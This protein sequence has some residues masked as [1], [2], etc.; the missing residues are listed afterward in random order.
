MQVDRLGYGLREKNNTKGEKQHMKTETRCSQKI[1]LWGASVALVLMQFTLTSPAQSAARVVA[2][3]GVVGGRTI[4]QWSGDWWRLAISALDFPFPRNVAQPGALGNVK[5]P[6]FFAVASPGPGATVYT[7]KV[8]RGKH[9][10]LPLYT[11]VWASQTFSDPCSDLPCSRALANRFVHGTKAL[12]VRIDG[13]PVRNLFSHYAA[14]PD[15]FLFTAPVAGWWAGGDPVF[16]GQWYGFSSGYW[17]MLKPLSPGRHVL[18]IKV[19]APY[20]S[21]CADGSDSCVIPSPGPAQVSATTLI[22]T[23]PCDEGER[24]GEDD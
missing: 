5:G 22:F 20:S 14:T 8:P 13:E 6:V 23:V 7:Y 12:K 9:V 24:C 19:A 2:P 3:D 16:A 11:Y 21:V 17:L 4:G 10:L 1:K 18:S 15:F